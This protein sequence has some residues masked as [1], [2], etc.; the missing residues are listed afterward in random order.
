MVPAVADPPKLLSAE[1]FA[2]MPEL[3]RFTELVKGEVIQMPPPSFLHGIVCGNVAFALGTHVR[4]RSLGRITI[5]DS[6][7]VTERDPDTV[8]GA[9]VA[10]F[11]YERLPK[12]VTP[13]VYPE[14]SPELVFEVMSPD[15]VFRDVMAKVD[16]YLDA[17]VTLVYVIDPS[18][19]QA[20]LF[21]KG[22]LGTLFGPT[23]ELTF[24][25]VLPDL[26]IPVGPLFVEG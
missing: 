23:N 4:P 13:R 5:N 1:E 25:G 17:G 26:R 10:Y 22:T 20:M 8:R 9:D 3:G 18:R 6:G 19:E 2:A 14:V 16:E 7:V 24:P 15:E 12:H 11:S 21:Q